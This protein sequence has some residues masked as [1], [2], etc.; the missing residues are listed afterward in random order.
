MSAHQLHRNPPFRAEHLGSLLRPQ[1]LLDKRTAVHKGEARAEELK[2]AE[3]AAINDIVKK[4]QEWG[5]RGISDGEY[6]RHMF[7]G[8]F[9]PGLDGMKEVQNPSLDMFRTY[10]PD[11]AAFLETN[12]IPGETVI[13]TGKI[14][15]TGK[16]TYVDQ[17]EYLKT[18]LPQERWGEIKLTLAAPNWYHLRYREGQAYPA[19]VYASDDEYF[20]DIAKAYQT[21]LDILYKA[22]LRNVQYDDPNLAYFCSEKMLDGWKADERNKY[23]TDELLDKYIKLYNDCVS[24]APADMHIGIHLCRGNFVGSR[25]FSE[26][27]YDR[28]A[29]KLFQEL[30]MSTYYLEYDTARAGGFEPLAH[31]PTHKNVILGIVTSKFPELED[32]DEMKKRVYAAADVVAKGSG[33]T[34]EEA[35]GRLGVSPQCGFASHAQGNLI[36][37]EGMARKMQLVRQVAD[38]VWPGEA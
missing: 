27:G 7:W 3:D 32:K 8:S 33:Q 24:K 16:S 6:R 25:H 31:L 17:V 2:P 34:R 28:I 19:D 11:M 5:F 13:C 30:N 38:E 4:Q 21:E 9:F 1:D 29:T 10:V 14:A 18:L 12:H 37:R 23:G 26:G 36:D 22:G 15:H 20:A 35:L